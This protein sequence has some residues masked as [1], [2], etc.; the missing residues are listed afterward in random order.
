MEKQY[1]D[2]AYQNVKPLGVPCSTSVM[3]V[4]CRTSVMGVTIRSSIK[5]E[6]DGKEK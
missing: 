3:G 5:E 4:P 6:T 2:G 1:E